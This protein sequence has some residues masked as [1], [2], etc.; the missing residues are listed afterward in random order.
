MRYDRLKRFL[1]LILLAAFCLPVAA[2]IDIPITVIGPIRDL[3]RNVT[4]TGS[5][6]SAIGNNYLFTPTFTNEGV[7]VYLSNQDPV[8]AHS[9]TMQFFGTGDQTVRSY[10]GNTAAWA[11]LGPTSGLTAGAGSITVN[12]AS[13]KN[14]FT[15]VAGQSGVA[16]VIRYGGSPSTALVTA[17][18]VESSSAVNCGNTT[19][20]PIYCPIVIT[21]SI[22]GSTNGTIFAGSPGQMNYVCNATFSFGTAP[23]AGNVEIGYGV[24][25]CTSPAVAMEL[26]TGTSTPWIIPLVGQPLIPRLN[27]VGGDFTG[28][29]L[30]VMNNQATATIVTLN[31]SQF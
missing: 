11:L 8:N 16:V 26:A 10:Q 27:G 29:Y 12:A 2:Q 31:I 25:N 21:Q 5:G 19:T 13:V 14:F 7:C 6:T 17:T 3:A 28:E 22:A 23:A 1:G 30:C 9:F 4:W 18:I 15:Q 24:G 20:G